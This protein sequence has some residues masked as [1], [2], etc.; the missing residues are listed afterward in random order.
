MDNANVWR[1]APGDLVKLRSGGPAMVVERSD[2][3]G[4]HC[5]CRWFVEGE[6]KGLQMYWITLEPFVAQPAYGG[7]SI[8]EMSRHEEEAVEELPKQVVKRR[9]K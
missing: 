1:P 8:S 3:S 6:V 9:G 7:L 2:A 5:Y 4:F